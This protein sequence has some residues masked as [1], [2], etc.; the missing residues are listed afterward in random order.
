MK[1]E[2]KRKYWNNLIIVFL[3]GTLFLSISGCGG[4]GSGSSPTPTSTTEEGGDTPGGT[5]DGEEE[6]GAGDSADTTAPSV[7]AVT[8]TTDSSSDVSNDNSTVSI[9]VTFSEAV[10]GVSG[11]TFVVQDAQS[12]AIS[13]TVTYNDTTYTATF[14]PSSRLS[15]LTQY[16]ASLAASIADAAGNALAAYSWSFTTRDGTWESA[17]GALDLGAGISANP[18]IGIDDNGNSTIAWLE[19]VE[20]NTVI[21]AQYLYSVNT[22][23]DAEA[24]EANGDDVASAPEVSVGSDGTA[25]AGWIQNSD[26]SQ[27][28]WSNV[29]VGDRVTARVEVIEE[30]AGAITSLHTNVADSTSASSVWIQA[31]RVWGNY[32][33]G[34]WTAD[35]AIAIDDGADISSSPALGV[36]DDGNP[37]V[38]WVQGDDNLIYANVLSSSVLTWDDG[39]DVTI[40][41]DAASAPH[42]AV[43][44]SQDAFAV[45]IQAGQLMYNY[46]LNGSW[47]GYAAVNETA[48]HSVP[49][50][51]LS[52]TGLAMIVSVRD[53]RIYTSYYNGSSFTETVIGGLISATTPKVAIDN[54]GNAMVLWIEDDNVYYSRYL[55]SSGLWSDPVAIGDADGGA[56]SSPDLAINSSGNV[57]AVWVQGD[58]IY[59]SVFR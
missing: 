14:V 50:V 4:G 10:S 26:G 17:A 49:Q 59:A 27:S 9:S 18:S 37:V 34:T 2:I 13:G 30:E 23:G 28:A 38:V 53:A 12:N 58:D 8:P 51:A 5:N 48:P 25:I 36:D 24:V 42:V 29:L 19:N 43:N 54:N 16:T 11:S 41:L 40:S 56:A 57:A 46:Y 55:A 15:L 32:Y 33:D 44:A 45:W 39:S 52:D 31:N 20:R 6:R 7:S 22:W 1:K 47:S 3:V 35:N 21:T